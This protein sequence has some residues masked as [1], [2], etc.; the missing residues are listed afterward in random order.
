MKLCFSTL[1]CPDWSFAEILSAAQDLGYDG[2]EIRGIGKEIDVMRIREFGPPNIENTIKRLVGLG[3]E[4][5]VFCSACCLNTVEKDGPVW[6][7]AKAYV[8]AARRMGV[9]FVRVLGDFSAA[10]E[11]EADDALVGGML[12]KIARY[13]QQ[14]SVDILVESNGS[15]SDSRRL[16]KLIEDTGAGNVGVVWDIHHPYRYAGE[17]PE[18]TVSIL[19]KLIA[20][21]HVKDSRAEDGRIRYTLPGDGDIPV[22]ACVRALEKIGYEGHLSFEWPKRWYPNLEE[23]CVAFSQYMDYMREII[24]CV[25]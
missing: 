25:K 23:P 14:N 6:L 9:K 15:Y 2:V 1:G 21:V 7:D 20:H 22:K 16:K 4:I 5:P 8:D 17:S 18:Q 10:P 12:K 13:A 11:R 3:I 19:G 24:G